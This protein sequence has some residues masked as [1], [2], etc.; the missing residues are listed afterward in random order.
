[1]T[2]LTVSEYD[3]LRHS[4]L[5]DAGKQLVL[6]DLVERGKPILKTENWVIRENNWRPIKPSRTLVALEKIKAETDGGFFVVP[7]ETRKP[8]WVGKSVCTIFEPSEEGIET[9]GGPQSSLL[10]LGGSP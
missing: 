3:D 10:D 5:S 2:R 7:S 9:A 4:T 6:N 8:E 1:M